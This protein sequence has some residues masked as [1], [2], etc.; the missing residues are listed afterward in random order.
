MCRI[1]QH[2]QTIPLLGVCT[3]TQYL[4]SQHNE[5]QISQ[6]NFI[7]MNF[8]EQIARI[9]QLNRH[10]FS[11]VD[12]VMEIGHLNGK[13]QFVKVNSQCQTLGDTKN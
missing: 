6:I 1:K 4:L 7:T 2:K 11:W 5:N 10:T 13:T 9:C 3:P 8:L 12:S